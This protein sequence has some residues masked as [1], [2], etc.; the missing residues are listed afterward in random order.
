[1]ACGF[2]PPLFRVGQL[3][4]RLVNFQLF[5]FFPRNRFLVGWVG[6]A[7]WPSF[8]VDSQSV[9]AVVIRLP[10]VAIEKGPLKLLFV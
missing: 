4:Y 10:F 2:L 1:M 9:L 8:R 3:Y 5:L 6:F 7:R